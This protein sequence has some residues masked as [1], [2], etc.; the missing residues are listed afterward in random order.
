MTTTIYT[1]PDCLKHNPG[2][3]IS[4]APARL[5]CVAAALK[6]DTFAALHWSSEISVTEPD[7]LRVH[8]KDYLV[9]IFTPI[10]PETPRAFDADTW[11]VNGTAEALRAA[12]GLV[13]TAVKDVAAGKT[14]NAF[15]LASPGGHHAEAAMALGFCFINH[16]AVGAALAQEMPEF[17]RVAVIDIDAH[18]ANG[19]QSMFWNHPDRLC[20]SLHEDSGLSGFAEETGRADNILN[21]PLP[22]E[23]DSETYLTLFTDIVLAKLDAFKPDFIFVS[24]GFDACKN[25]PLA[26]LALEIDDYVVLGRQLAAAANRLCDGRLVAVMEGGY[27]LEQLGA[28]AAAF[29]SGL[30]DYHDEDAS[31][32]HYRCVSHE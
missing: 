27:N 1:H 18:H 8:D 3:D 4:Y 6:T 21:I 30:M 16:V 2:P 22:P 7:F 28:C 23:C 29:V 20:I 19:T 15:C 11:A 14:R 32:P 17:K 10:P 13:V 9:D 31:Y 24:A 26:N 5:D 25:D 12:T